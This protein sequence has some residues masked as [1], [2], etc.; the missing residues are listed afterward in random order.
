MSRR[1]A[2]FTLIE[3]LVVISIIALLI[4]ILLPALGAARDSA[5][6]IA[7]LSNQ[8]Q[9]AIG[10]LAYGN[11]HKQDVPLGYIGSLNFSYALYASF[12][13]NQGTIGWGLLYQ[14]VP[15]LQARGVWICP[16]AEGPDWLMAQAEASQ[17][18]PP[19]WGES[20]PN[21]VVGLYMSR[22]YG[23]Q[24]DA[25]EEFY[26]NWE[27]AADGS[28]IPANLDRDR[29]DSRIAVFADNFDGADM[30][31]QRHEDGINVAYGD[32][33]AV[34]LRRGQTL[35]AD[36][37]ELEDSSTGA[38]DSGSLDDLFA[39][40]PGDRQFITFKAWPLLDR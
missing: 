32:G 40:S 33:S 27:P 25:P 7:C 10:L 36:P 35:S 20:A 30:V 31:D 3:L 17:S 34:F 38:V 39:D 14:D 2:A 23:R 22:P 18:P 5:R 26:W 21:D 11:E 4:G 24:S 37:N 19:E 9:I 1:K 29:I 13:G 16:S 28:S 8:R 15:E 12:L 6:D